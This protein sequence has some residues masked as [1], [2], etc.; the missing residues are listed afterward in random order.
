MIQISDRNRSL[1]VSQTLAMSQRSSELRAQGIDVINL[2]VGEPD[3]NTPDHIKEAA[4]KAIENAGGSI[5]LYDV[6]F[7]Y[8]PDLDIY[9]LFK[10]IPMPNSTNPYISVSNRAAAF[11]VILSYHSRSR[12][13]SATTCQCIYAVVPKCFH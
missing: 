2:S 5:D 3:F 1:A 12:L 8:S 11:Y 10:D 6:K 4:K 13:S 9:G 7:S